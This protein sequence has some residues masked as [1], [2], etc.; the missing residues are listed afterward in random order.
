MTPNDISGKGR[1][2]PPAVISGSSRSQNV[3][4]A[5]GRNSRGFRAGR[6]EGGEEAGRAGSS[7]RQHRLRE[8][9]LR[10]AA[11]AGQVHCAQGEVHEAEERRSPRGREEEQEEGG[12]HHGLGDREIGIHPDEN[13]EDRVVGTKVS[14]LITSVDRSRS[15]PS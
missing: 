11:A 9:A 2:N 12:L 3:Q 10:E 1:A 6:R 4:G 13:G 14:F 15:D 7:A 8:D 5:A